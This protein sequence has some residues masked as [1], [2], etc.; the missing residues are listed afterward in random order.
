[1]GKRITTKNNVFGAESLAGYVVTT[2]R[3]A[4]IQTHEEGESRFPAHW[5]E[6]EQSATAHPIRRAGRIA[7][8]LIFSSAQ[9]H[10]FLPSRLALI[11]SY[12]EF[13]VIAF[14]REAF[15]TFDQ[16]E[17][18][19]MPAIEEQQPYITAFS[20]RVTEKVKETTR[21]KQPISIMEAEQMVW[22]QIKTELL[23]LTSH[24]EA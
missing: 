24:E 13:M 21:K 15:Y 23:S 17:L 8:C 3:F 16:I 22:K 18:G 1:M 7:G 4:V 9:P 5:V 14:E 19:L 11:E 12:T 10:Y 2:G 20:R 6:R